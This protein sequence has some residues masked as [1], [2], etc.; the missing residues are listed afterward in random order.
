MESYFGYEN[1]WNYDKLGNVGSKKKLTFV[2]EKI[3]KFITHFL[4][5]M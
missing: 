5:S 4:K 2:K 3:I 1:I